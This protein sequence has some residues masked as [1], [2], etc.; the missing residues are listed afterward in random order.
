MSIFLAISLT[1][2]PAQVEVLSELLQA[3]A[4]ECMKIWKMESDTVA[5]RE[6]YTPLCE[7]QIEKLYS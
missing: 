5:P 1:V 6:P 2:K 3:I 7:K 4:E